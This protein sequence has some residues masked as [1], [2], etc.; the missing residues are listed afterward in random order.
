MFLEFK[1]A[2]THLMPEIS[3][4]AKKEEEKEEEGWKIVR[5]HPLPSVNRLP[6][7]TSCSLPQEDISIARSRNSEELY[8]ES[9]ASFELDTS[10]LTKRLLEEELEFNHSYII[11]EDNEMLIIEDQKEP[12]DSTVIEQK[13]LKLCDQP[14]QQKERL[15]SCCE[16]RIKV[17]DQLPFNI[18]KRIFRGNRDVSAEELSILSIE[19]QQIIE[20][21]L[22]RKFGLISP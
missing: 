13:R 18:A 14:Q 3:L 5:S 1:E 19:E 17:Q 4:I 8:L 21:L 2:P 15:N 10:V 9:L 22:K 12:E 16:K 7:N 11:H 6:L 20:S